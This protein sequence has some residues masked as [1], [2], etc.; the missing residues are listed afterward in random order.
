MEDAIDRSRDRVRD[1]RYEPRDDWD[2]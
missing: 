2:H 1:R